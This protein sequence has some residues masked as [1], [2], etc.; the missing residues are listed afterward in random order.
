MFRNQFYIL[1]ADV[2]NPAKSLHCTYIKLR[3]IISLEIE[4]VVTGLTE[5]RGSVEE[6]PQWLHYQEA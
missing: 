2:I 5:W 4:L 6:K 1:K 3:E